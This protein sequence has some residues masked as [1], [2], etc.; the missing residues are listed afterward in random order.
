VHQRASGYQLRWV[1][2]WL[3]WERYTRLLCHPVTQDKDRVDP[4]LSLRSG[5]SPADLSSQTLPDPLRL[6]E[7]RRDHT[8]HRLHQTPLPEMTAGLQ[9]HLQQGWVWLLQTLVAALQ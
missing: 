6:P 7:I 9:Q 1:H 2:P 8:G 4:R 5:S 3:W